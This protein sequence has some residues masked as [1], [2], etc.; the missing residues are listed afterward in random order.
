ML[1][2]YNESVETKWNTDYR[3]KK[4]NPKFCIKVKTIITY[5]LN[6]DLKGLFIMV[7]VFGQLISLMIES[8]YS[9]KEC[10]H[11]Y[12]REREELRKLINDNSSS[13]IDILKF[14]LPVKSF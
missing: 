8:K 7:K 9:L 6:I 5:V 2:I 13:G 11:L 10:Q 14:T 1:D 3:N 4:I 12:E